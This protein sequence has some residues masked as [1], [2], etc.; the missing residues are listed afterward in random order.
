[1]KIPIRFLL[2]TLLGLWTGA[3]VQAA[4][5]EVLECRLHVTGTG[6]F[7]LHSI[8]ARILGTAFLD[9]PKHPDLFMLGDKYY[10]NECFRYSCVDRGKDGVPVFERKVAD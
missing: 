10:K 7:A 8:S 6:D 2:T 9:D 4:N 3:S 1:M 5:P